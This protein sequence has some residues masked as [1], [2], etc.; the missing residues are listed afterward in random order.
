VPFKDGLE[1]ASLVPGAQFVPLE[2]DNHLLLEEEPAWKR[3][4]V[5]YERFM[6]EVAP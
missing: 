6:R 1:L 5:E 4:T 3:F 2:S